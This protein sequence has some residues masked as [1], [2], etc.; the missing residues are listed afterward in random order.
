MKQQ[1]TRKNTKAPE[2]TTSSPI[3]RKPT[4]QHKPAETTT[5]N[6]QQ[7]IQQMFNNLNK[8]QETNQ[9]TTTTPVTKPNKIETS[10]QKTKKVSK[11]AEKKTKKQTE[12]KGIKQLQGF[13]VKFAEE[14]KQRRLNQN[15]PPE[16]AALDQSYCKVKSK[17]STPVQGSGDVLESSNSISNPVRVLKSENTSTITGKSTSR[18]QLG[19]GQSVYKES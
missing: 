11:T 12:K 6:K 18:T 16:L 3:I 13:W 8:Q 1:T 9:K 10:S 7:N 5:P 19:Q 15:K 2:Q 14:Q 17:P 4:L